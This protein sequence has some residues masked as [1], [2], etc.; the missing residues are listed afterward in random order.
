MHAQFLKRPSR[1][2]AGVRRHS[3]LE[4]RMLAALLCWGGILVTSMP[5]Q[6][7]G[8]SRPSGQQ[9]VYTS[10]VGKKLLDAV[11]GVLRDGH[12]IT[13]RQELLGELF[14]PG[15]H[16]NFSVGDVGAAALVRL[17]FRLNT[18]GS[19]YIVDNSTASSFVAIARERELLTAE[20]QRM[21]D[22]IHG[23]LEFEEHARRDR[24]AAQSEANAA[25]GRLQAQEEQIRGATVRHLDDQATITALRAELYE[26]KRKVERLREQA[27]AAATQL[28][29]DAR[30][31]PLFDVEPPVSQRF[32]EAL[33][34]DQAKCRINKN[35]SCMWS[36][37]VKDMCRDQFLIKPAAY[38]ALASS[39]FFTLPG[40]TAVKAHANVTASASGH[41]TALYSSVQRAAAALSSKQ[42]EV[43]A[44][45]LAR[46]LARPLAACS[47]APPPSPPPSPPP[48]SPPPPSPPPSP[49]PPLP[50]PPGPRRHP[51]HHR[52]R[53]HSRHHRHHRPRRHPRHH[54]PHR[55]PR[56]RPRP[57]PRRH[58]RPRRYPRHHRPRRYPRHHRPRHHPRDHRPRSHPRHRHPRHRRRCPHV[59]P[60]PL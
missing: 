13:L 23:A 51:R 43:G 46:T 1:R 31:R 24:A 58:Y 42:R 56:R 14:G 22:A 36:K 25:R 32:L 35:N 27:K 15:F 50:L 4:C 53:R 6:A 12:N 48:P 38:E 5:P 18:D 40:L 16:H 29:R 30:L 60:A 39:G 21:N 55:R 8:G 7:Y 59:L 47:H 44:V 33:L 45:P 37:E 9:H 28:E 19:V 49:P 3:S 10:P 54:R 52:P 11:A 57:R 26:E 2:F 20:R 41:S 34:I 17:G